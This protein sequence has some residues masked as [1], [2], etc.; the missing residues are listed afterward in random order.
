MRKKIL[1]PGLIL[2]LVIS[3]SVILWRKY[4]LP[5]DNNYFS[6]KRDIANGDVRFLS[7]GLPMFTS[8]DA[9][10][11]MVRKKYGFRSCNMGCIVTDED[12]RTAEIYNN[13]VEEYLTKRN[14]KNWRIN[15]QREVDSL[16]KIASANN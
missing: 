1:I 15:F 12:F 3:I 6:A 7:Y 16:Y 8:K 14:G 10:I 4:G 13:T 11:E 9:E 2:T 5:S